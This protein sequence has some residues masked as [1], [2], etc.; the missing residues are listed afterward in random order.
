MDKDICLRIDELENYL[1]KHIDEHGMSIIEFRFIIVLARMRY[2]I[3]NNSNDF[4]ELTT[5]ALVSLRVHSA[6][7]LGRK[8]PDLREKIFKFALYLESK[9]HNLKRLG[10]KGMGGYPENWKK[11]Y[12]TFEE[13]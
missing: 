13:E 2:E 1:K 5:S 4:S 7:E 8:S 12:S 3:F 10:V 9:S 6:V 11:Y